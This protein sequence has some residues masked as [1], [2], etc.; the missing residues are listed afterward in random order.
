MIAAP[1]W[2]AERT[3]SPELARSLV[4][5]RFPELRPVRVE[6]LSEGWDNVAYLVNGD[7]VFRFPRRAIA[8]DLL[9]TEA[10]LLP[11]IAPYLPLGIPVPLFFGEADDRF[12]WP[13]SGYRLIPG[14]TACRADLDIGQRTRAAAWLGR[15][16]RALHSVPVDRATP[17]GA[18]PDTL[19]RMNVD[20]RRPLILE[21]LDTLRAKGLLDDDRPWREL[22]EDMPAGLP[23]E[24][25]RLVHGDF[26]VR[27]ILVDELG[28]PCGVI[29][30]GDVHL[31][32]PALDL[33]IGHSFL[34]PPARDAFREAYGP[35]SE[36]AW[37]KARFRALFYAV[38]L[39][40]YGSDV[41]DAALV[42]EA[43]AALHN[44]L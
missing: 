21:R 20:K 6:P 38:V 13:F 25:P 17:A 29:D 43:R 27:H 3:V 12:P 10:A 32:D 5:D 4:E 24:G 26:Y 36:G 28:L 15:F 41:S 1:P 35:I 14:R 39:L 44:V 11:L 23:A 7:L 8:V 9:R 37:R 42:R 33:S 31:G 2:T 16:L 22:A 19:D 40:L 34:P 30:W 18:G